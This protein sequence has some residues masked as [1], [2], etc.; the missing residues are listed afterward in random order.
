MKYMRSSDERSHVVRYFT[1]ALPQFAKNA[2][3]K[4]ERA[5]LTL[6]NSPNKCLPGHADG[7]DTVMNIPWTCGSTYALGASMRMTSCPNP[8]P[9]FCSINAVPRLPARFLDSL[10]LLFSSRLTVKKR[11]PLSRSTHH[12]RASLTDALC[13]VLRRREACESCICVYG[14]PWDP[15]S[16]RCA[17]T[18][19]YCGWYVTCPDPS[20]DTTEHY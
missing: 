13:I 7:D 20:S 17:R 9:K 1:C 14:T 12:G 6:R 4:T 5:M 3:S 2:D 19:P 11:P 16:I 15:Y 18:S 10:S 8:N